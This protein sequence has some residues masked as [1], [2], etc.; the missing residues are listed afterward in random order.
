MGLTQNAQLPC[1]LSLQLLWLL[2]K[3]S[4]PAAL[5]RS[6]FQ[7]DLPNERQILKVIN[8][9]I[10]LIRFWIKYFKLYSDFC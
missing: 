10:V 1:F 7:A 4:F 6:R 3:R 9:E 8:N 5:N 2:P